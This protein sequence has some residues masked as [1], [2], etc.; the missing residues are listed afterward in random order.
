MIE[1]PKPPPMP[2]HVGRHR[3]V[4]CALL[5]AAIAIN[6]IDR[7]MIGVLKP[8]LQHEFHW[9]EIG[10]GNIIFWFQAFYALGYVGF[11]RLVDRIGARLGY[12]ISIAIWTVGHVGHAFVS[13]VFGFTIV[14]VVLGIGESGSFPAA[15]KAVT[16]WFPQRERAFATGLFNAGTNVG[17]IITPLIVPVITLAFGWRWAFILTG[18][19]SIAWLIV[20]LFVYRRPRKSKYVGAAEIAYIESDPPDTGAPI[21]WV[22]LLRH[23][24]TW[25]FGI[26][27]LL[28]DPVWWM[29][30]FWLPDFFAKRYHL[31]LQSFGPPL[32]AVY[33]L[34]D[35]GSVAGGWMS[36]TMI[37]HGSSVNRARKLTMLL[38]AVCVLPVMFARYADT[39]WLAVAII[40]LATAAHQGF[41]ANLYTLASDMFPRRA[42]GSVIGIG[43][44]L[45]GIGG[46]AMSE[47]TGIVLQYL[48]TY[49]PIFI[50][51]G[52]LYLL[53][54]LVIHILSPRLKPIET[55]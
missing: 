41:S 11:G 4:I 14:R 40:G 39:V 24:Q 28:I 7:Q 55:P 3:W 38:C 50:V 48:G 26:G 32:V 37:K 20:W 54:L 13:T 22:Q 15:I 25:A 23:R 2:V 27:K 51:A 10:Y 16:E 52:T 30:L 31:D 17:A 53:A 1:I 34:S 12:T 18:F 46:M 45:G 5:F 6:Y 19:L 33:I 9:T 43:G 47:Y 44:M 35:I 29:F 8:T 49:T 36:S 42:V 21:P